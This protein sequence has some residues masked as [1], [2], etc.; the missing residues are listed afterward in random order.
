ME[1]N[2]LLFSG[3]LDS[4]IAYYYLN[5]PISIFANMK[6]KY[7]DIELNRVNKMIDEFGMNIIIDN[8][9]FDFSDMELSN[10]IIPNR[11]MYLALLASNYGD[12]IWMAACDGDYNLDKNPEIFK[13]ASAF[14]SSLMDRKI[15]VNTPFW[16]WTKTD[17]IKWYLES[18]YPEEG[19]YYTYSCFYGFG[20]HCGRCKSCVRRWISFYNN[21][22]KL[23]FAEDPITWDEIPIYIKR[24]IDGSQEIDTIGRKKE[25][26]EAIFKYG[27]EVPNT[28]VDWI[29]EIRRKYS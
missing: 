2:V 29:E 22:L 13:K 28:N 9:T 7:A 19:L 4:Y 3:G 14:F 16:D 24:F 20:V 27:Y 23:D 15:K 26:F 25:F 8:K 21:G 1:S 18:G 10:A 12:N 6:Q 11:N 17:M 5:K